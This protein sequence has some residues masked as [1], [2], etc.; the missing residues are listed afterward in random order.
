MLVKGGTGR[1]ETFILANDE[2]VRKS[3]ITQKLYKYEIS[4]F[5]YAQGCIT[6]NRVMV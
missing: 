4:L 1:M 5:L 6:Q 2:R 3:R